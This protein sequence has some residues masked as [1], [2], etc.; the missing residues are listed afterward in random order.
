V[1]ANRRPSCLAHGVWYIKKGVNRIHDVIEGFHPDRLP[2]FHETFAAF[3]A[4]FWG[5]Q[6]PSSRGG[7]AA[8]A[9]GQRPCCAARFRCVG[10]DGQHPP[11]LW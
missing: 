4:G 11:P 5:R 3:F 6:V 8:R 9:F 2:A 1:A 10:A 7:P